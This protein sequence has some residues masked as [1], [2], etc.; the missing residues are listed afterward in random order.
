VGTADIIHV[1]D[2]TRVT[3][4]GFNA[5]EGDRLNLSDVLHINDPVSQAITNFVYARVENGNTIIS[6]NETGVGGAAAAHDVAVL[7]GVANTNVSQLV[8]LD[9]NHN[10]NI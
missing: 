1:Q 8:T 3:V 6:V 5:A 10:G 7:N 9:N 4:T 2:D